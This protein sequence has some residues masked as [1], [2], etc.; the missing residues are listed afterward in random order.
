MLGEGGLLEQGAPLF[1]YGGWP[2]LTD[3]AGGGITA[4]CRQIL[5]QG[6]PS[7]QVISYNNTPRRRLLAL[8]TSSPVQRA[9]SAA[10]RPR[11]GVHISGSRVPLPEPGAASRGARCKPNTLTPSAN[12][13]STRAKGGWGWG[14][15]GRGVVSFRLIFSPSFPVQLVRRATYSQPLMRWS[16]L[17]SFG[18]LLTSVFWLLPI[19]GYFPF[20]VISLQKRSMCTS[21][22]PSCD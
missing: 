7:Q 17:I 9:V 19:F 1:P 20:V 15:E 8:H 3:C 16:R 11:Q 14:W 6:A 10:L 18:A 2:A 13:S 4:H 22:H 5:R 12:R 21:I